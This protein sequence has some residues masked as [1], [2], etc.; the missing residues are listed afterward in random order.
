MTDNE[1]AMCVYRRIFHLDLKE[2]DD[3]IC[4]QG[5]LDQIKMLDEKKQQI[6]EYYY[7]HGMTYVQVGNQIGMSHN[8]VGQNI[9]QA[10][11]L[12]KHPK[13]SCKMRWSEIRR[14]A[15]KNNSSYRPNLPQE[16]TSIRILDL[17]TRAFNCLY[18]TNRF[19]VESILEMNIYDLIRIRNLGKNSRTEVI[20][21][22]HEHGYTEWANR[23]QS[24]I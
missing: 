16:K 1:Y 17:S 23:M 12:L 9:K 6:L 18:K 20:T 10:I 24:A 15:E 13:R 3:D 21:K 7:R 22:M 14:Q 11:L 19:Y 8:W 2:T 4:I 5:V